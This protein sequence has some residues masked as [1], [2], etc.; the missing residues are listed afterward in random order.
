L[1]LAI[2][3]AA[4][5]FRK[6]RPWLLAGWCWY[7]ISLGPVIGIVQVGMQSMADRYMYIPMIGLLLAAA[8]ELPRQ[9]APVLVAACAIL[10]WNQVHVWKD[11]VTLFEHALAVTSDNF[12]AHNSLGVELDQ[13]N[14]PEAALA[15]YREAVRIRPGDRASETNYSQALFAKGEGLINAG[16]LAE[17]LPLFQEGLRHQPRNATA[18]LYLGVVLASQGR[19]AEALHAIDAALAIQPDLAAAKTARVEVRKAMGVTDP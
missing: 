9:A 12:I 5:A 8:W 14:Q 17:A 3:G 13:R 6:E 2:T 7:V 16:H 15:H 1:L 4:L 18:Q 19:Y 10:T 11:G